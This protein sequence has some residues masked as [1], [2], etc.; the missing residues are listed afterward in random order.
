V[1]WI[2]DIP[3]ADAATSAWHLALQLGLAGFV[4][5]A[6]VVFLVLAVLAGRRT[7]SA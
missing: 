1:T 7:A 4:V 2:C 6:G 5:G 3:G